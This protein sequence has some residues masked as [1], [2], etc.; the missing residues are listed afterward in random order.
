MDI[1][2]LVL[3][4]V[5]ICRNWHIQPSEIERMPY[6]EYEIARQ[7]IEEVTKRENK[8]QEEESDKY[9]SKGIEKSASSMMKG[10]PK[11]PKMSMSSMPKL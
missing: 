4:K 3:N 10:V 9:S 2:N 11:I 1:K 7:E 6:W 8:Q 5:H